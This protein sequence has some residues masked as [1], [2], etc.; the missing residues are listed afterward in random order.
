MNED[1]LP[2]AT[3][4]ADRLGV[5][6]V[7]HDVV[8]STM[9]AAGVD[10]GTGPAIHL[11]ERQ[12]AG[13]GRHDRRWESPP[14]NLYAT[15]AWPDPEGALPPAVLAAIQLAW[16]RTIEAS[17]GPTTSCKWPN[18]G[19]LG[20]GKWAGAL[21]RRERGPGGRR[22]LVGLGANLTVAPELD[23]ETRPSAALAEQWRPWPGRR[24]VVP[25]LLGS[26]LEVLRGG[27]RGVADAL[28]GWD[29]RDALAIGE[30]IA[31]E[32]PKGTRTGRYAGVT[33]DGRLRLDTVEGGTVAVVV[34][35]LVR[36]TR[37]RD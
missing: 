29:R 19:M 14:G 11:A 21:A 28:A 20:G 37:S 13:R 15:V 25:L 23:D 3:H 35:D 8:D 10:P 31:V 24:R 32:T 26:A 36:V 7:L 33:P 17:G 9:E 12:R 27:P 18:D 22:L 16:S 5:R 2:A 30:S 34:G 4:L 6:V 1:P